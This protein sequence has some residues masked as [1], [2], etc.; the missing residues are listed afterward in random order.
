M[1]KNMFQAAYHHHHLDHLLALP[2]V[3]M[4]NSGRGI[5][6]EIMVITSSCLINIVNK[7]SN[8]MSNMIKSCWIANYVGAAFLYKSS[9]VLE[10]Y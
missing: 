5:T 4:Y 6:M 8:D 9:W 7:T 10:C 2:S 3:K 1:T